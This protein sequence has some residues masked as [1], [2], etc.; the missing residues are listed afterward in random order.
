MQQLTGVQREFGV[1]MS[2]L[3]IQARTGTQ[4]NMSEGT[5]EVLLPR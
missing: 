4:L 3:M 5:L 1:D 2:L